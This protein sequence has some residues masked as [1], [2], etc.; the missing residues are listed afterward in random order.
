MYIK[1]RGPANKGTLEC[2]QSLAELCAAWH[3]AEPSNG[4]YATAVEWKAKV[5]AL[6][7]STQPGTTP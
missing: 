7:A 6:N 2:V 1:L 4:H 5:E 3:A